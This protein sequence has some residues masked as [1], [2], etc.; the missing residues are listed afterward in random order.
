MLLCTQGGGGWAHELPQHQR[1]GASGAS[2]GWCHGTAGKDI[3]DRIGVK[4]SCAR[5]ALAHTRTGR[6][7]T[8]ERLRRVAG[9]S[10]ICWIDGLAEAVG[11]GGLPGSPISE[12]D[13]EPNQPPGGAY[14]YR[15]EEL[16]IA[17]GGGDPLVR[18]FMGCGRRRDSQ[19]GG[20]KQQGC[21]HAGNLH[22]SRQQ[23]GAEQA[24]GVSGGGLIV[25]HAFVQRSVQA[26]HCGLPDLAVRPP[27]GG[28][29]RPG[30]M[31][32]WIQGDT[33]EGQGGWG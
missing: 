19:Q 13:A 32:S 4:N 28:V 6:A 18:D 31:P 2:A 25:Q 14:S 9:P 27:A 24:T 33:V 21:S 23:Q 3:P 7:T 29:C 15:I 22:S 20:H 10:C 17:V 30:C 11:I 26:L 8:A 1:T 16:A 12:S 5:G